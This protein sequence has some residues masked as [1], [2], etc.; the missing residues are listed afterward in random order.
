MRGAGY[1][2]ISI[3]LLAIESVINVCLILASLHL[4]HTQMQLYDEAVMQLEKIAESLCKNFYEVDEFE[5]EIQLSGWKLLGLLLVTSTA[6]VVHQLSWADD[7]AMIFQTVYGAFFCTFI[8]F[9][10]LMQ[11]TV[12]AAAVCILC[13]HLNER[14][15]INLWFPIQ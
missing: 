1:K 8:T 12:A 6:I 9:L 10:H 14:V 2:M 5:A 7:W 15:R 4:R 11:I 3:I 13:R